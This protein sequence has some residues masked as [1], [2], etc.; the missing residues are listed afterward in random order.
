MSCKLEMFVIPA[1]KFYNQGVYVKTCI[2]ALKTFELNSTTRDA[3]R[4]FLKYQETQVPQNLCHGRPPTSDAI[5]III[6]VAWL[7]SE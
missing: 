7:V 1:N 2:V 4:L 6:V 5:A 3:T